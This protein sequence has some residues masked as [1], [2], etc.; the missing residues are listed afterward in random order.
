MKAASDESKTGNAVLNVG[1]DEGQRGVTLYRSTVAKKRAKRAKEERWAK[2]GKDVSSL[3]PSWGL[4]LR[5][6]TVGAV[7]R[8]S[9]ILCEGKRWDKFDTLEARAR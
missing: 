2:V 7:V 3:L 5:E 6:F 4:P 9:R 1:A 8:P